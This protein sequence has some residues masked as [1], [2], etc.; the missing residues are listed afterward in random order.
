ME[1]DSLN[2]AIRPD[3]QQRKTALSRTTKDEIID[4]CLSFGMGDSRMRQ[5]HNLAHEELTDLL[6]DHNVERCPNCRNWMDSH[7]LIHP[8]SG[9]VDGLCTNCRSTR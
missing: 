8:D 1:A 7:S 9:D 6:L 2:F 5:E 4:N 3:W